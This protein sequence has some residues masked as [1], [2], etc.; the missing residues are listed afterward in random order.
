MAHRDSYTFTMPGKNAICIAIDG[1]RA[2]ALG[3][4]GNTWHPTPALDLLAS[5]SEIFDCTWSDH[6]TLTGFYDGA[7][8]YKG[9]NIA[10]ALTA[11]GVDTSLTTD[12]RQL[13]ERAEAAGFSEVRCLEVPA[14]ESASVV[15]DTELARLFAVAIDQLESWRSSNDAAGFTPAHCTGL[16]MRPSNSAS[17]F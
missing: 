9:A 5:Q 14:V 10:Q 15:A 16:G 6:P 2:S 4:Y 3:A 8:S 11:Q 17:R 7:W 12:D 13:A 1:L